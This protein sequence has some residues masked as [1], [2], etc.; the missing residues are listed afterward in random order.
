MLFLV[1]LQNDSKTLMPIK[2][3]KLI[4]H[5]NFLVSLETEYLMNPEIVGSL[6]E[7][8]EKYV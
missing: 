8:F 6:N 2:N 4:I 1:C 5:N 3:K 7:T